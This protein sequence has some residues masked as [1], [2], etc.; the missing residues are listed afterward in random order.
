MERWL[1]DDLKESEQYQRNVW[2]R[3]LQACRLVPERVE[4]ARTRLYSSSTAAHGQL[5][6]R[7]RRVGGALN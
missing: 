5:P 1:K 3:L 7:G 4:L 2:R 6:E